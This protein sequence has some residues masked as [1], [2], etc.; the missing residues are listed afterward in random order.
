MKTVTSADGTTIA[1]DQ[2]GAGAPVIL[3]A[4]AFNDRSTTDPLARALAQQEFLVLNYD[5]RGR[6]DSTDT[7]PYAVRR[8][9]EDLAVLLAAAGG[10]AVVVG[11]SSG[12]ALAAHAAAAGL[13]ISHLVLWEPPYR[14]DPAGRRAA[15]E[16]REQTHALLAAD[17]RGDALELFLTVVGM[18]AGAIAGMQ[19]SPFWAQGE[20][21]APTLAHD[22]DV[23]GAGAGPTERFAAITAATAVLTGGAGPEWFRAAGAATAAAI[24]GATHRVLAG[25]THDVA[26]EVLAAA[27]RE[28]VGAPYAPRL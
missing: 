17:R 5:R 4:G 28:F 25:Q 10:S 8:E 21:L 24:P 15:R 18:P 9:I 14:L 2:F 11:L 19:R 16:Y 22:A 6:G 7:P 1:F 27:V 23:M 26:P 12:A 3:A 13:P 20:A